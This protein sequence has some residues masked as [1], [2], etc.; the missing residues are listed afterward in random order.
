MIYF[1]TL[2]IPSL[3]GVVIGVSQA[4]FTTFLLFTS[5]LTCL[6]ALV[7]AIHL[8]FPFHSIKWELVINSMAI[9]VLVVLALVSLRL[10]YGRGYEIVT[11][12]VRSGRFII[13]AT[14][15]L[16]ILISNVVSLRMLFFLRSKKKKSNEAKRE[17]TITVW[18]I[19][20]L[21]SVC[22]IGLIIIACIP[23][24]SEQVY[25]DIP[26]EVNDTFVF[27]MPSLNSACN[28]LIYISRNGGMRT[29][30]KSLWKRSYKFRASFT[31]H[32]GSRRGEGDF[33]M[34]PLT[35]RRTGSRPKLVRNL[36]AENVTKTPE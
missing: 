23:L 22:N 2:S 12:V 31:S 29:H 7:R 3:P 34:T 32:E 21:Y 35:P 9:Y 25:Y 14:L 11:S 1:V 13:A 24:I 10:K 18:I 19:S 5:F 27:I 30:L 36:T 28:P 15:F 4:A 16:V 33:A 26:L 20:V 8:V 17:I 6:L